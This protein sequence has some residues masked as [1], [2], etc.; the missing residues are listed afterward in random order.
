MSKNELVAVSSYQ[1]METEIEDVLESLQANIGDSQL[2]AFDLD[3]VKVPS[4]GS[5]AWEVPTL[6][7]EEMKK[8]L[9]GIPV[10]WKDVRAYWEKDLDESGGG[11]PPD[12]QSDDG[13]TGVGMPGGVC[14]K[15]PLAEFG[16]ASKGK[17]QACKQMKILF[18]LREED[19]L[20]IAIPLPPTSLGPM[21][22]FFVRLT[23]KA[24]PYYGA[25]IGLSLEKDK[26]DAGI[27]Y[28][29]VV[30]SFKEKLS[31]EQKE[32]VKKYSEQLRPTFESARI[33][34]SSDY[35]DTDGKVEEE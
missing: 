7:G 16:S 25:L 6:N 1:I 13:K 5:T 10:Y 8:E 14:A 35:V 2:T 3:R 34:D 28:A 17:G 9:V 33:D 11:T 23:S 22:K 31:A 20:P 21:K 12:C 30:P 32:I 26:N 19:L 27:E 18:I 29:K 24:I 4:G 15:C